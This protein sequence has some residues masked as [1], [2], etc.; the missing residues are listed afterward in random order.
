MNLNEYVIEIETLIR[1][2]S[3]VASYN[4]SIDKKSDDIVF[5]SG[6]LDFRDGTILDFKEFVEE[7]ETRLEKFKYGYNYRKGSEM[8]FRYDNALDPRARKLT[9]FPHHKHLESGEIIESKVVSLSEVLK[10][11]EN[12]IL[13]SL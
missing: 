8:V 12:M 5:I 4:L 11:I 13:Q 1:S 9:S 2:C 7:K 3:I 10:E 6:R